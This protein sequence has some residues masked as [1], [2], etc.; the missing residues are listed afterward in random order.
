MSKYFRHFSANIC[1]KMRSFS[2]YFLR[3]ANTSTCEYLQPCEYL[4]VA[5]CNAAW[6]HRFSVFFPVNICNF[7]LHCV[8]LCK[9]LH[10]HCGILRNFQRCANSCGIFCTAYISAK[11]CAYFCGIFGVKI[12]ANICGNT[13]NRFPLSLDCH[14][15]SI[16]HGT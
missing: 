6:S 9:C 12:T 13:F 1:K 14:T 2:W 15:V 8:Y 5:S 7:V 10:T 4:Q 3:C 16:D 11:V